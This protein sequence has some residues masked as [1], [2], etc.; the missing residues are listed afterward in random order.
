MAEPAAPWRVF[1]AVPVPEAVRRALDDLVRRLRPR[2][3]AGRF[4]HPGQVHVT[5]HFFEA[6]SAGQVDAV[7]AIARAAAGRAAPFRVAFGGLGVF[8]DPRRARVLWTALAEGGGAV[9]ALADD[10][11]Q[12]LARAGL[13]VDDRPFRPH[14]T[15]ARFRDPPRP[16]DLDAVLARGG[17]VALPAFDADRLTLYRSVLEPSGAVHSPIGEF[18][19]AGGSDVG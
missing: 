9:G 16:A 19:L 13:P 1:L 7:R 4:V 2:L 6:L 12:A 14:L 17:E 3:P 5:L 11:G 18:P 10:V 8:P 15:L